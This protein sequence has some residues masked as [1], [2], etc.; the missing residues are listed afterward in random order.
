MIS[1]HVVTTQATLSLRGY[2]HVPPEIFLLVLGILHIITIMAEINAIE[3]LVRSV[4]VSGA[5]SNV[6]HPTEQLEVEDTQ[7]SGDNIVYPSGV[8]KW[9]T[10]VSLCITMFLSG[11]V[12]PSS[13]VTQESRTNHPFRI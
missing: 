2:I 6:G 13:Y 10:I 9:L 4:S 1:V 7:V 3:D 11:L 8:K 12:G 5:A